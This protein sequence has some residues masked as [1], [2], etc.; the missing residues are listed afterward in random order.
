MPQAV[1]WRE[2]AKEGL[3]AA[4]DTYPRALPVGVVTRPPAGLEAALAHVGFATGAR[5]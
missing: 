1:A 4:E 3:G 5:T 2:W